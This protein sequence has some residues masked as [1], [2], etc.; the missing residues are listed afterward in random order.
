MTRKTD[1]RAT[2][3]VLA[4]LAI[5]TQVQLTAHTFP[6]IDPFS[7]WMWSGIVTRRRFCCPGLQSDMIGHLEGID[8]VSR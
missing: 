6:D 7:S 8:R 3:W 5:G 4:T 2:A 1:N